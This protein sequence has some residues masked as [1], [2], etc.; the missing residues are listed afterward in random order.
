MSDNEFNANQQSR[1]YVRRRR[2]PGL[3]NWEWESDKELHKSRNHVAAKLTDLNSFAFETYKK[4]HNLN[5]NSGLNRLI[6][7]HPEL[8]NDA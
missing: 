4:K 5:N 3:S 8:Q 6:A 7:T 1:R 2:P